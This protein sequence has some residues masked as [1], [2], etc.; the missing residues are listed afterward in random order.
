MWEFRTK[1]C[2]RG[3][4]TGNAISPPTGYVGGGMQMEVDIVIGPAGDVWLTNNRQYYPAALG[5]VA[6]AQ[7]TLGGG[8][9]VMVFYGM[10]QAGTHAADRSATTT[11]GPAKIGCFISYKQVRIR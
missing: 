10:G 8:Q 5:K 4:K 3:F 11:V 2:P 9:G 1:N 6:E 7:S